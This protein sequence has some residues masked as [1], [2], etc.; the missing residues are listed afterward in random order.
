MESEPRGFT[1]A[2]L[3]FDI[4]VRTYATR[5]R[6]HY[7]HTSLLMK[8]L[9]DHFSSLYS[10]HVHHHEHQPPPPSLRRPSHFARV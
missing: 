7:A 9:T 10:P 8:Y 2:D 6:R 1:L 4:L 3:P 5:Y